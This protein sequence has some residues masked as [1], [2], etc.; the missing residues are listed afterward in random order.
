[1]AF[2]FSM[3]VAAYAIPSLLA[4]AQFQVL[5]KVVANAFLVTDETNFGAAAST[6]LLL[7]AMGTAML[8]NRVAQYVR[9]EL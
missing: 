6:V 8:L 9:P 7:I 5:S 2:V 1:M 4:G 3:T